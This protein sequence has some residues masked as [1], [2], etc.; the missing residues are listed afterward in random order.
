MPASLVNL[1]MADNQLTFIPS[2]LEFLSLT[3][4]DLSNNSIIG[5]IPSYFSTFKEL[6]SLDISDNLMTGTLPTELGNADVVNG[7]TY[8]DL[9]NNNFEGCIPT[10]FSNLCNISVDLSGNVNLDN[11]NFLTFCSQQIGSCPGCHVHL[12]LS[13]T[14]AS[15]TYEASSSITCNGTIQSGANVIFSAP[16]SVVMTNNF[17]VE[18]TA[19]Y[20]V[21]DT[22]C[23]E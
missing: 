18:N 8:I 15:G 22:G 1:N 20:E 4:L 12:N 21:N 2:Q 10:S 6:V 7:L 9:S 11:Q 5:N 14:I 3:R 17:N 19:V 23:N 13:G 16:D